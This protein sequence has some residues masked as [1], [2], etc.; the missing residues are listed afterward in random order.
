[1]HAWQVIY[2][3]NLQPLIPRYQFLM[4]IY[5]WRE[6]IRLIWFWYWTIY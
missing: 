1:L 5:P 3:L 2:S 6:L 4:I